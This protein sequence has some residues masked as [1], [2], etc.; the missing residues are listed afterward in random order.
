MSGSSP[1]IRRPSASKAAEPEPS[2][3]L[4]LAINVAEGSG[5]PPA[6]VT[7][8]VAAKASYVQAVS[9]DTIRLSLERVLL[10]SFAAAGLQWLQDAGLLMALL[11]EVAA[12]VD[13]GQE[14]GRRHKD[15]WA[16]TKQVVTQAAP[17]PSV[18]WAALLHDVGKVPTRQFTRDGK[19]TFHGHPEAGART[20][21]RIARRLC[22]SPDQAANIR[23]LIKHHQRLNQYDGSW[24][25][26]AVRRFYRSMGDHLEE[27]FLLSRADVTSTRQHRRD[28][29]RR[30]LDEL[31]GRIEELKLHD[32]RK[33]ALPS[34]LGHEIMARFQLPPGREVGRL[35]QLLEH[36]VSTGELL[37][38]QPCDDYLSYIEQHFVAAGR[39]P[40]PSGG[41]DSGV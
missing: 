21:D 8:R 36:A 40:V 3:P 17:R 7:Q 31:A 18:R 34:G 32:A 29:V 14:A 5:L 37:P 35:R 20:F 6:E 4:Q 10:G 26:S 24:S 9:P 25:D 27:L 41:S 16:H 22:F 12:T 19:V 28:R 38:Q 15:V 39:Q 2:S 11:P 1:S 33:P 30:L 13:F 23:W